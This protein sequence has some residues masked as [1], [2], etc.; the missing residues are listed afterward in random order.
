MAF[1]KATT[2]RVWGRYSSTLARM[3]GT[4]FLPCFYYNYVYFEPDQKVEHSFGVRIVRIR[5]IV[6]ELC[7]REEKK[8]EEQN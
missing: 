4:G 8:E 6:F 2:T 1:R 3:H 5:S 7:L